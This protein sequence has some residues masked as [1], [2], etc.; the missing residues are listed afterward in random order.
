[1]QSFGRSREPSGTR[2]IAVQSWRDEGMAL[3][4]FFELIEEY[5]RSV[6]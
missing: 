6:D 1:V 5:C 3:D 2:S 4:R